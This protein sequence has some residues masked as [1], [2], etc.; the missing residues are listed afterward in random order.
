MCDGK[1][2]LMNDEYDPDEDLTD[3]EMAGAWEDGQP[4]TILSAID[5]VLLATGNEAA[6]L[7]SGD[8]NR[9]P[10]PVTIAGPFISTGSARA[11]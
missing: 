9:T 11:R 8:Y 10:S 4:V 2:N 1:E 7:R 6:G 5:S 3:R